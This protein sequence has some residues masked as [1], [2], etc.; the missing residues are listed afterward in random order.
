MKKL[1]A[2][3]LF[4]MM[5]VS[6]MA[7]AMAAPMEVEGVEVKFLLDPAKTLDAEGKPLEEVLAALGYEGKVKN[8]GMQFLDVEGKLYN[9]AGWSNRVR[10]KQGKDE[11][12]VTF[13]KRYAVENGDIA[14]ALAKAEA[15]AKKEA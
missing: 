4:V 11:Y 5:A 1:V 14:A 10:V 12:D 8:R 15:D 7:P 6:M 2:F 13:K 3:V 9:E